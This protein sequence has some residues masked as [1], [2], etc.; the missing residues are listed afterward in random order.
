MQ[1]NGEKR[2]RVKQGRGVGNL[3][4]TVRVSRADVASFMLDQ[5]ETN[6]Y[7]RAAPGVSW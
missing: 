3:L 1:R 2:G 7:L 5:L 4:W 6:T